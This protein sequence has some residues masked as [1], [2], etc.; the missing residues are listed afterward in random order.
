MMFFKEK[1][2]KNA[3]YFQ[4]I[5][6]FLKRIR[7]NESQYNRLF[8][9][10]M[11]QFS[12][13]ELQSLE[14][15]GSKV[16]YCNKMLGEP[17]G[18]GSGRRIYMM[19]DTTVLKLASSEFGENANVD[20]Y[21]SGI[22]QNKREAEIYK[23]CGGS[24]YLPKIFYVSDDYSFIIEEHVLDIAYEDF[25]YVVGIPYTYYYAQGSDKDGEEIG[26]DKYFKKANGKVVPYGTRYREPNAEDCL[27][28]AEA[29]WVNHDDSEPRNEKIENIIKG[30]KWLNGFIGFCIE[31]G[32]EEF[33]SLDSLDNFGMVMRDGKP[34]IVLLDYGYSDDAAQ[35]HKDARW[36]T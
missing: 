17:C 22:A 27:R 15:I 32:I 19:S 10:A 26:F 30:N 6:C 31:H 36:L 14:D 1:T 8:E 2:T 5:Y 11:P 25:E 33:G 20:S 23:K 21:N 35:Y 4:A 28:Y 29:V 3:I 18:E 13:K 34:F 9:A 7:I 16:E 24:I 12:L